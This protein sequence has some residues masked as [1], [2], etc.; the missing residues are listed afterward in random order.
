MFHVIH[1]PI[2][3]SFSIFRFLCARQPG[4]LK[5][6]ING[7]KHKYEV[8]LSIYYNTVQFNLLCRSLHV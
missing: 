3:A 4:K 7:N 5:M 1:L 8:R 6:D 2:Q